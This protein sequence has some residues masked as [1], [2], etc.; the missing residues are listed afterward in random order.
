MTRTRRPF[1]GRLVGSMSERLANP[2]T[3]SRGS[4]G[5]RRL[6]MARGRRRVPLTTS[7]PSGPSSKRRSNSAGNSR[8]ASRRASIPRMRSSPWDP[9]MDAASVRSVF[10]ELREGLVPLVEEI[11]SRPNFDDACLRQRFPEK[12][13][14]EFAEGIVRRFGYDFERGRHD[15]TLHPFFVSF[16]WGDARITTRVDENDFRRPLFMTMHESGHAIYGQGVRKEY[17]GRRSGAA[18]RRASTSRSRGCGRTSSGGAGL[19][20]SISIPRRRGG[21]LHTSAMFRSRSFMG[22]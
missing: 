17:E 6:R 16:G 15:L 20:G 13:K 12:E 18:H 22:S 4:H 19:S 2:R 5:T 21:S 14:M 11:S 10:S 1:F 3:S 7:P 8:G 9:G